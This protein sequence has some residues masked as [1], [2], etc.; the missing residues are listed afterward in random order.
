MSQTSYPIE[1]GEAYAGMKVDSRFDTVESKLAET[2]LAA[3]IGFGIG[4]MSG[5]EDAVNQVRLPS[6][7]KSVLS[8]DADLITSNSTVVTING[9]ALTAV[10]FATDHATTMAAIAAM[11]LTHA[12]VY[13]A[14]VS[15]ARDITIL[16]VNGVAISAS[17]VT[18]GGASQG[19]WT[20][21][22]SDPG[23]FRGISVHRHME[24]AQI[25][26]VASYK[27]QDAVD[28]LRKGEIW[29]PY[30]GT[31]TIDTAAYINLAIAGSEGYA[32]IVTTNNI[33]IPTGVIREINT[34]LT[35]VKVEIN[36]P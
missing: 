31:P 1:Q 3:G 29:M 23:V 26:G 17:A 20:Q 32:T 13:S 36:M 33:A 8:I 19:T 16:G 15:A 5:V 30:L 2:S 11:I 28:V 21:V 12:D 25:T 14:V 18:T 22:Q 27:D 4:L 7:T 10:V 24:K 9:D 34:A 35:L 6:K